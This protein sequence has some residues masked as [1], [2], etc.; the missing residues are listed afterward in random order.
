MQDDSFSTDFR[1]ADVDAD[2]QIVC[3]HC[4]DQT[5]DSLYIPEALTTPAKYQQQQKL[6]LAEGGMASKLLSEKSAPHEVIVSNPSTLHD[7]KVDLVVALKLNHLENKSTLSGKRV[8][9]TA[10][11]LHAVETQPMS[12][13]TITKKCWAMFGR[14]IPLFNAVDSETIIGHH[15]KEA[16][17][18]T[19]STTLKFAPSSV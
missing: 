7:A 10:I 19:V 12:A 18:P 3:S 14:E 17:P 2:N 13:I 6:G 8:V 15:C 5:D 9:L 4:I 11:R 1:I 16:P